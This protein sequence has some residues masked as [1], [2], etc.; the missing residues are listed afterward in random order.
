MTM[1]RD[2][3]LLTP[4]PLTTSLR[5]RQSMLRD[6]GSWD[7]DF[8]AITG[9]IRERLLQIAHAAGTH[10]CVPL[11]G[12][13]TFAVEAAI[14]TLV[15]RTGHVLVPQNGAYCQRI[16]RICRVL[17]RQLSTLDYA[18]DAPVAAG[19]IARALAADPSI[20]HVALVHCE[21]STGILN[22]LAEIAAAVAA[23][24]RELIVDAMSSFGALDIDARAIPFA[25]VV[26]ASGK[27]LEGPPGMG[28]VLARRAA[29]E[30]S[31]GVSASLAM[32]LHDQWLYMQKTTQW[33]FTPPTHVVAAFDSAIA[34][35]LEEGG[36]PARRA[37]YERNCDILIEGLTRQGL[38]SFLP[39]AIQAPIIV[40]FYAPDHPQYSF[41]S[42]YNAVKAEGYILYPG[43]LT[44]VETFRVGCMGQLGERGMVGAVEAVGK[45]LAQLRA[46]A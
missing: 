5:T 27:C 38:R 30:R 28:F 20:T 35:Y 42:F 46:A 11:Q 1:T 6:W 15:P 3:Y 4:G 40:T 41:K 12:S 8:N 32:D 37:R 25:A 14:G 13:G 31:G 34:Q 2:P 7:S 23:A 19:D 39:A 29:L 24:G 33:R 18:E 36:C 16:A 21:T 26:A 22:P 45:V 44:T 10:E 9:R 43:K 17:G